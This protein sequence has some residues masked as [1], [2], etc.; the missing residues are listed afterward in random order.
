MRDLARQYGLEEL[1]STRVAADARSTSAGRVNFPGKRRE[2]AEV[3]SPS[4]DTKT[5]DIM[6]RLTFFVAAFL[7]VWDSAA[8]AGDGQGKWLQFRGDRALTGRSSLKGLIRRPAVIWK[9]FV[10]GRET[11]LAVRFSGDGPT[12][13][14]LPDTNLHPEE[15]G[16]VWLAGGWGRHWPTSRATANFTKSPPVPSI[17]SASS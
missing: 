17:A 7:I 4:S 5:C 16:A 2:S 8:L 13:I 3:R 11:L 6:K 1:R 10:G 9:Q 15:W 12:A 14:A